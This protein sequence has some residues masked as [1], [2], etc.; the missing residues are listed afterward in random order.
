MKYLQHEF[1]GICQSVDPS[2]VEDFEFLTDQ[3]EDVLVLED[4][5]WI[6]AKK[7]EF[8]NWKKNKHV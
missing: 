7:A 1:E 4:L 2:A 3:T 5:S 6:D 8:E